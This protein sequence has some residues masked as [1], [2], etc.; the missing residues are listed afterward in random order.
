MLLDIAQVWGT[1][2][3]KA[4]DPVMP[5]DLDKTEA[6]PGVRVEEK[7]VLL[8]RTGNYRRRLEERPVSP[9]S[10]GPRAR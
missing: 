4:D 1:P 10:R 8:V 3:L 6:M 7:D 9:T 5:E 2:W